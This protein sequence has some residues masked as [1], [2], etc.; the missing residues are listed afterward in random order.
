MT[1]EHNHLRCDNTG[2]EERLQCV[3]CKAWGKLEFDEPTIYNYREPT[4]RFVKLGDKS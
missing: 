2:N 4:I 1:C 3:G